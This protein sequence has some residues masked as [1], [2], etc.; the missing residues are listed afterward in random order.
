MDKPLISVIV[1][2]YNVEKYLKCCIESILNQS[3]KNIEVILVDDG[4]TDSSP[5][6][7][8]YYKEKDDRVIVI[9]KENGGL[10]SA[11]NAGV[12]I[13]KGEYINY[14]DSDDFVS[15]ELYESVIKLILVH[16]ADMACFNSVKCRSEDDVDDYSDDTGEV[17]IFTSEEA[18]L[19]LI[20]SPYRRRKE[21]NVSACFS[22]YKR[23][24]VENISFP[25]GLLYEDGYYFP[26][27]VLN[28]EKLIHIDKTFYF[29]RYNPASV[30]SSGVTEQSLKS[31][32]DWEFIHNKVKEKFPQHAHYA[33]KRWITRLLN[34]YDYLIS[35]SEL[36]KSGDCKN[37]IIKR[38]NE[39]YDYFISIADDKIQKKKLRILKD[40]PEKYD[41]TNF[42]E[43]KLIKMINKTKGR[44]LKRH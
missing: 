2:V 13:A 41:K 44:I 17:K 39:N 43:S 10:S 9:H 1:P 25:E 7:C 5:Q 15:I 12:R 14:V 21:F 33:A 38:I 35:T 6:I 28:A 19:N 42:S 8:D 16:K 18:I 4:S 27:A 11:R 31:I 29:Y 32:D 40:S 22:I 26:Q 30:M 23:D 37:H 3:Y 36:D 34:M 20:N 24:C